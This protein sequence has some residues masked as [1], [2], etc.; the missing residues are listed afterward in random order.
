MEFLQKHL[1]HSQAPVDGLPPFVDHALPILEEFAG[2]TLTARKFDRLLAS[3]LMKDVQ[4]KRDVLREV[5]ED[6][7]MRTAEAS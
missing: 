4:V 7:R 3:L 5:V 2:S 1:R 6:V